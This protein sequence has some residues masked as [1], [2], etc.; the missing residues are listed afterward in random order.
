MQLLDQL[1][2]ELPTLQGRLCTTEWLN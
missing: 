2:E 1:S